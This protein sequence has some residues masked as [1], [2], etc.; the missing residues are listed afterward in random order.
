MDHGSV[1][2]DLEQLWREQLQNH[3]FTKVGKDF[4]DQQVQPSTQPHPELATS[5]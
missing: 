5:H 4:S 2:L 1:W 3:G